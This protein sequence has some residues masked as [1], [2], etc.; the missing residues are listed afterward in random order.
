MHKNYFRFLILVC[1]LIVLNVLAANFFTRYDLTQDQRYSL[2]PAAKDIVDDVQSPIIIDVYLEGTFP[3]EFKRLQEET[4]QI[5]EEF[6]SYNPNIKFTFTDPLAEGD[7]AN[8]IAEEFYNLGMIPARLSIQE[9][10]KNSESIIFPWA[11]ANYEN[12]TVKIPLLKN[13]IGASDEERVSASVQQLEYAFANG[14]SKLIYS[15]EKKIAVMRGNGELPDAQIADLIK[16]IQE[17]YYIAPFTLDSVKKDPSRTLKDLS[18]YDLIIEAKPTLAYTEDEKYVLDQYLMQGGRMLWLVETT[19]MENDS[20]FNQ[21]GTAIALPRDLNLTDYFFSYGLRINPALVND[22]Y[23]APIILATGS[24]NDTRF[25]PYPWYYS[26]LT[27][28]TTR[29]PIVNNIEAVKFNYA[30]P[31]DLLENDIAKTILLTSS[32][33]TKLEAVPKQ[34]SL[35]AI[36]TKPLLETYNQGEQ[37]LAVLLEGRFK[38]VYHNRIK[39]FTFSHRDR[40]KETRIV[41]VSDGDV[42]KNEMQQGKPMELGYERYTGMTYG[43]KEFLLNAVNY[44][45]DDT[46]LINIRSKEI[47]LAFLDKEKVEEQRVYWQII[48]SLAPLLLLGAGAIVFNYLRRR[49]YIR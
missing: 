12:K 4:R 21:S 37:P 5:L 42:I 36:G 15:R 25:N 18:A 45:L 11:I 27:S 31:I 35:D 22:L 33:K 32:P 28:S 9:N 43:N 19:Q 26:P 3:S 39:P 1:I 20:L 7:N 23:S 38:S 29:H 30:N 40:S 48:T 14:L 17:Y 6:S 49:R 46:G 13:Q 44:L 16:T 8:A 34:L 10:G 47:S 2:S 24:G 41:V